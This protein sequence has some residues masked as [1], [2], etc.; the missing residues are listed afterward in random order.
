MT[1]ANRSLMAGELSFSHRGGDK[2]NLRFRPIQVAAVF[3][4]LVAG[5]ARTAHAA[6]QT[7][8]CS[9]LTPEQIQKVLG[10]PFGAPEETK[11]PPA[12]GQ[13][14]WGS[15]CRYSSKTGTKTALTFIVYVDASPAEAKQTFDRLSMWYAPKSKPSIGDFA[16]IDSHGA[17]HVLKGKVRYFISIDPGN[18]KQLKDLATDVASR[19]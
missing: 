12:Y 5:S 2:M 11:A 13:Q 6:P 3:L 18:E 14:P 9:L 15:N 16:Y 7:S 4:V 8:G 19:I 17:I 1:T 10:Q